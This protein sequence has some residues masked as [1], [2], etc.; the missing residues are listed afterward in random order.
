[1]AQKTYKLKM[2]YHQRRD[3]TICLLRLQGQTFGFSDEIS[4]ASC[5]IILGG[6]KN[7]TP[8]V[9]DE[10]VIVDDRFPIT[11]DPDRLHISALIAE[12]REMPK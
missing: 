7:L 11:I 3:G 4:L 10:E 2:V 6:V 8:I 12:V 1:M 5:L 9:R